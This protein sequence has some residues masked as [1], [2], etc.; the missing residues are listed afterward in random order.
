MKRFFAAL[1]LFV[2]AIAAH[3]Q[4]S[5]NTILTAAALNSA[6][7]N[8]AI[9]GGSINGN[10]SITTSGAVTLTGTNNLG[11]LTSATTQNYQT[12]STLLATT[13]FAKQAV[14]VAMATIPMAVTSGVYNFAPIGT[15]A[16]FGV[17]TSGG[18]IASISSI[19]AGGT[20]YQVGD[21]LVILGGNGDALAYVS[22]VSSGVITAASVLYG[23]SGYSGSPQLTGMGI[24]PGSRSRNLTGTLTGNVTIIIPNGTYLA[25]S[26]RLGIQNN[27]TGA[28][29]VTV[30]LSNGAGGSMGTGVVIPQGSAN[31]TSTMLFTDG[32]NDVWPEVSSAPNF[33]IPGTL[34]LQGVSVKPNLSG[35][36]GSLGGSSVGSGACATTTVTVTGAATGM[37]VT[38]T[39]TTYPGD[40]FNWRGYVSAPNTVTVGVCNPGT[41]GATPTAS[42]YNVRVLQ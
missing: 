37:V 21:C 25:A 42:V 15:G 30:K 3:A 12:N 16:I 18:A 17:T 28:F 11:A 2:C 5:P 24:Q 19:V 22:S 6:L 26:R 27:T 9:T 13:A 36:T 33:I 34:T 14:Q 1:L 40:A 35:T 38:A 23:G 31:S 20:G 32:V 7:A 39:P 41:G 4:F 10:T 8:P 29:T